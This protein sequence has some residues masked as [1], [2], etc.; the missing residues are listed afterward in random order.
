MKKKNN[1]VDLTARR[2]AK[3]QPKPRVNCLTL[4]L[5]EPPPAEA[6]RRLQ[7]VERKE[8]VMVDDK[9]EPDR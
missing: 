2:A 5:D 6:V 9:S 1:V 4:F 7:L 3:N 8:S